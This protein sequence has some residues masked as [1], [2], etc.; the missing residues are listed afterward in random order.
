MPPLHP[1]LVH[2]PIAF[3]VLSDVF[4]FIAAATGREGLKQVGFWSLA[5]ALVTGG[6]TIALGYWDMSR[7][8]LAPEVHDYV[9]L[10]LKIGWILAIA[11]ALLCIWRWRIWSN[12]Q[13]RLRAG[14]LMAGT[15]VLFLTLFQGWYG[16]EMVY[17]HGAGV[18]AA[19]QGTEPM[20]SAT[21]RL[22]VVHK[23]L[24]PAESAMGGSE[25]SAHE[26]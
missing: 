23:A 7:A 3:V 22:S 9:H 5:A 10:H 4:D 8:K 20:I 13:S 1:A 6:I 2:F 11:V 14:Y 16:G 17:S 25:D 12:P 15:L 19:G 21:Q 24:E 18:A 26:H